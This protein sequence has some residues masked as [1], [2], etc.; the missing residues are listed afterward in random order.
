MEVTGK[1]T[2]MAINGTIK[3]TRPNTSTAWYVIPDNTKTY[4]KENFIDTGKRTFDSET[5]SANGLVKTITYTFTNQEAKNAWVADSTIQ[6]HLN[7]RDTHNV[8]NKID[9]ERAETDS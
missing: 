2:K 6:G 1:E 5:V 4:L 8:T 7:A 3:M 9:L